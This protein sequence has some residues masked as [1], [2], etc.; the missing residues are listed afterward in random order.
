MVEKKIID[1]RAE[2]AEY[3]SRHERTRHTFEKKF[4]DRAS[5]AK[6]VAVDYAISNITEPSKVRLLLR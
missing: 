6:I 5:N 1:N 3:H 2:I 4:G